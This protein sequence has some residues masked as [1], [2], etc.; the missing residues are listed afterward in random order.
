M[1]KLLLTIAFVLTT[2]V[3]QAQSTQQVMND[4]TAMQVAEQMAPG[5]NLGNTLEAGNNAYNYKNS[6]IGTETSWQP[7]KTSQAVIDYVKS[8]GFRSIR[9]PCAWVMG[10]ISNASNYTIDS[11]W[12]ERVKRE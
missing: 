2:H 5:W 8:L 11:R 10:H 7:T 9:I 1:Q 3:S 12:M 4:L 6:G